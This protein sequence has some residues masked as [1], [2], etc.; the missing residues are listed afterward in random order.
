MSLYRGHFDGKS[1]FVTGAASGIGRA[2]ALALAEAGA[3]VL[4][5]DIRAEA[6]EEALRDARGEI[7]TRALDVTERDAF[8]AA[9]ASVVER[10]GGLDFAFLNAGIAG[11]GPFESFDAEQL[12]RIVDVNL[13]GVLHG[14]HVAYQQMVRQGGGHIVNVASMAGLHPVPFSTSYAATKHAVVGLSGSLREEGRARGVRVGAVCPGLV[15][16]G[17][18]SAADDAGGYSYQRAVASMLRGAVT[19]EQAAAFILEG[20]R[21]DEPLILFPASSR[22][23]HLATRA[24]PRLLARAIGFTMRPKR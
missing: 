5:T 17:I 2:L 23:L 9:I 20:T 13:W 16:T 12:R 4:A 15:R 11:G 19:P 24:A 18:F 7:R 3:R 21:R 22:A 10:E 8:E 14:T 6:L 1:A